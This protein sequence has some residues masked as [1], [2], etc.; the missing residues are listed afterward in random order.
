MRGGGCPSADTGSEV[1]VDVDGEVHADLEQP[2]CCRS[3]DGVG[4]EAVGVDVVEPVQ[5]VEC[6]AQCSQAPGDDGEIRLAWVLRA[7]VS[8]SSRR[9][10]AVSRSSASAAICSVAK[11]PGSDS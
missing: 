10:H 11:T 2:L 9:S 3:H 5:V 4:P 1:G 6:V 7:S 8:R